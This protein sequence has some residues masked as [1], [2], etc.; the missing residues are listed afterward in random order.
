M[1]RSLFLFILVRKHDKENKYICSCHRFKNAI[2]QELSL[3][4]DR[5][6][7]LP[8]NGKMSEFIQAAIFT[9]VLLTGYTEP[10][11]EYAEY[12]ES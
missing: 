2:C 11:S 8:S 9:H 4:F 1:I 10:F 5:V 7:Q 6:R 12:I 3:S